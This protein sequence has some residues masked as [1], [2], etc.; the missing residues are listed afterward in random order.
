MLPV[1]KNT[2]NPTSSAQMWKYCDIMEEST[3]KGMNERNFKGKEF[4]E[5]AKLIKK[6][7]ETPQWKL[8]KW[9]T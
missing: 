6:S 1:W 7:I 9:I 5:V 4:K 3:K 8:E 2:W